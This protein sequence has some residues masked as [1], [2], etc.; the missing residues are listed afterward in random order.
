MRRRVAVGE[1]LA[2]RL[3]V[4]VEHEQH[5]GVVV[6]VGEVPGLAA[7]LLHAQVLLQVVDGEGLDLG[8]GQGER[9]A[10]VAGVVPQAV[11]RRGQRGLRT[12]PSPCLCT[13]VV[14]ALRLTSLTRMV[15]AFGP[16]MSSIGLLHAV[17]TGRGDLHALGAGLELVER[18]RRVADELRD[19]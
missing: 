18:E 7:A 14:L 15:I 8:V 11:E 12:I 10:L 2:G 13:T 19:R 17:E 3:D 4:A 9:I 5:V 16:G 1:L 6:L